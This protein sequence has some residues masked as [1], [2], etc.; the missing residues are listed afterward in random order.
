VSGTT[1]WNKKVEEASKICFNKNGTFFHSSN[2]SI[3]VNIF[4]EINRRLAELAERFPQYNEIWITETHHTAKKDSPSGTA[5]TLAEDILR[6]IR[7]LQSWKNYHNGN[8]MTNEEEKNSTILPINSHRIG[9]AAG[10]HEVEYESEEDSIQIIHQA[11]GRMGFAKGAV[12]AAEFIV[13]KK[14]VFG[15]KDLLGI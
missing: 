7:R 1:G 3:G 12:M 15:M 6:N 14:G 9:D 13:D 10:I 8:L 4:F 5:I 2:F 11:K